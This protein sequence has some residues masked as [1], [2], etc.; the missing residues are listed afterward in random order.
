MYYSIHININGIKFNYVYL[1]SYLIL[2]L[3]V[4]CLSEKGRVHLE[5][6]KY[7]ESNYMEML[8]HVILKLAMNLLIKKRNYYC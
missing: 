5:R 4:I 7:K 1:F 6:L 2:V 8:F 3:K